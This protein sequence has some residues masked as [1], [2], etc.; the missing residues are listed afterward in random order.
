MV[1]NN[2][3][4]RSQERQ[5]INFIFGQDNQ[6]ILQICNIKNQIAVIMEIND[7]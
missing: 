6:I 2:E 7:E 1:M 4:P 5:E 3:P